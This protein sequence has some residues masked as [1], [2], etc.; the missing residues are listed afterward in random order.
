MAD[1]SSMQFAFQSDCYIGR[2][3]S[4][5]SLEG[6][7]ALTAALDYPPGWTPLPES[8]PLYA[9]ERLGF[10][11]EL[12][13]NWETQET[14]AD[15]VEII[16]PGKLQEETTTNLIIERIEG[17][18]AVETA[19]ETK[20]QSRFGTMIEKEY[21]YL[22]IDSTN[23]GIKLDWETPGDN[24]IVLWTN[25]QFVND[26]D[27]NCYLIYYTTKHDARYDS[28]LT[29]F[30]TYAESIAFT[31]RLLKEPPIPEEL[32]VQAQ[33][34]A[35]LLKERLNMTKPLVYPGSVPDDFVGSTPDHIKYNS[36]ADFAGI[37]AWYEDCLPKL[38][39]ECKVEKDNGWRR[40]SGVFEGYA[41]VIT[42]IDRASGSAKETSIF[43]G[44]GD[45]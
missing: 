22:Y 7:G 28:R 42:L 25:A 21:N 36:D 32:A 3:E 44:I 9:N 16:P 34:E 15:A 26:G 1:G 2:N 30:G 43:I 31:F 12:F 11:M 14:D 4:L 45:A 10:E 27:G 37:A 6:F 29:W 17:R 41:L 24:G 35:A 18:T 5:V 20:A 40:Y 38:F 33:K 39:N 13:E 23:D 19:A 8:R